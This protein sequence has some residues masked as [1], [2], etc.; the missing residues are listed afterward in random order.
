[1]LFLLASQLSHSLLRSLNVMDMSSD[2]SVTRLDACAV[3]VS[4]QYGL[5]VEN[6]D[7]CLYSTTLQS[8]IS[9]VLLLLSDLLIEK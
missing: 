1:M 3:P 7:T 6:I 2:A 4:Q 5:S 9:V 8:T